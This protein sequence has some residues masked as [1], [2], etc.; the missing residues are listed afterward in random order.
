MLLA[1]GWT[2]AGTRGPSKLLVLEKDLGQTFFSACGWQLPPAGRP[3]SLFP[4]LQLLQMQR[5]QSP[6]PEVS[7]EHLDPPQAHMKGQ[8]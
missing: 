3:P 6:C 7:T 2:E 5:L 1:L 8:E 4:T